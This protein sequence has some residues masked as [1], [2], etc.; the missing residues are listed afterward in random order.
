M[1][2]GESEWMKEDEQPQTYLP[3]IFF[4]FIFL[5]F[6]TD[7]SFSPPFSSSPIFSPFLGLLKKIFFLPSYEWNK[8][9]WKMFMNDFYLSADLSTG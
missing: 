7:L 1:R 9:E 2:G 3:L 6:L 4:T 5:P 8:R